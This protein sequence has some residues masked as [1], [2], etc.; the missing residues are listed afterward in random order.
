MKPQIEK[1][2]QSADA[3]VQAFSHASTDFD[4]DVF[5]AYISAY[6]QYEDR[7]KKYAEIWL[8]AK[9]ASQDEIEN[10]DIPV[11][12]ALKIQSYLLQVWDSKTAQGVGTA[13][14]NEYVERL[15]AY[16]GDEDLQKLTT[17]V[18][19]EGE[20]GEEILL[21]EYLQQ[22][23]RDV[24]KWISR[25]LSEVLGCAESAI[26]KVLERYVH[27]HQEEAFYSSKEKPIL[28]VRT[29]QEAVEELTVSDA[30]KSQLLLDK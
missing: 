9:R 23:L 1:D 30:R 11:D 17:A 29:W 22:G 13:E 19:G 21:M 20:A 2:L 3:V 24:P 10:Q 25:R 14:L 28:I 27:L 15:Y 26:A 12:E 5:E 6:P 8:L 7:I 4:A 18:F 16:Q